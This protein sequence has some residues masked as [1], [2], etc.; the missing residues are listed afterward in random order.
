MIFDIERIQ[1]GSGSFG[2]YLVNGA[3]QQLTTRQVLATGTNSYPFTDSE[4]QQIAANN[5]NLYLILDSDTNG[6]G[7]RELEI[8]YFELNS[9]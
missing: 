4:E 2:F 3:G 6:K 5:D 7:N 8:D 9:V 1:I